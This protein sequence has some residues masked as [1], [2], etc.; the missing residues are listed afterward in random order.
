MFF[1]QIYIFATFMM[2]N[3]RTSLSII[4]SELL[5]SAKG[6]VVMPDSWILVS[7]HFRWTVKR[8]DGNTILATA[9]NASGEN[10]LREL[11]A[12]TSSA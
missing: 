9:C 5:V 6:N 10:W 4:G 3:Y 8:P 11:L 12:S 7:D 2:T 1:C